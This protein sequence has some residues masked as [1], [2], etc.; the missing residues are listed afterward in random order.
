MTPARGRVATSNATAVQLGRQDHLGGAFT[1]YNE[2][3]LIRQYRIARLNPNGTPRHACSTPWS[4]PGQMPLSLAVNPA[5]R[6]QDS[7]RRRLRDQLRAVSQRHRAASLAWMAGS[8]VHST[9]GPGDGDRREASARCVQSPSEPMARSLSAASSP[10]YNG[11]ARNR[12][13]RLNL[14]GSLDTTFNPG[15][16]PTAV[17]LPSPCSPTARLSSA[18]VFTSYNNIPREHPCRTAQSGWLPG[19]QRS[20][21]ARE[22]M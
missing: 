22:R 16:W 18:G 5:I 6:R 14:D 8:T 13:A 1:S 15:T 11:T 17:S 9:P 7:H 2:S 4:V 20:F 19:H 12:I 10:I 3:P 21:P